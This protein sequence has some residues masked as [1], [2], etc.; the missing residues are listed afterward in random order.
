MKANFFKCFFIMSMIAMFTACNEDD[1]GN[2]NTPEG[3]NIVTITEDISEVTTWYADSL[4]VIKQ[5]DF[6]VGNSLTIQPGTVIKFTT[7]GPYLLLGSS[8]TIIANGTAEKPIVFTS[9]KDDNS[10]GDTNGDGDA[11]Q[12]ARKDWG[13]IGTNSYNGSVFNH[14]R[15]LYGGDN[16][17]GY[18]LEVYGD[19]IKVTNSTFAHN[20]GDDETGWYGALNANYAEQNCVITGNVFY[21]NIRPMSVS[22]A[23]GIDNSNIFHDPDN[24]GTLNTYNAIFIESTNDFANTISWEEDEVAF[25]IDDVDLWVRSGVSLTLGDGVVVKFRPGSRIVLADGPSTI[26]NHDGTGVYFTSYKDDSKKGDA[27]GDGDATSPG[28]GDWEGIYDDVS[29]TYMGWSNIY[30]ATN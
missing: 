14:C 18:T 12:P 2:G 3:S 7:D 24:P 23:I 9:Y 19:N 16:S 27:N 28:P 6:Y 1:P 21:D 5:Y 17:Y 4:Y 8:G 20:A 13:G 15:F 29:S 26:V 30:Y 10:G 22:T 11:T 25:V